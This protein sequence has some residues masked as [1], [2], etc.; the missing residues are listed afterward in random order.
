MDINSILNNVLGAGQQLNQQSSGR[1]TGSSLG[2]ALGSLLGGSASSGQ[3]GSGLGGML[4]G[5]LGNKGNLAKI[6]G[7]AAAAGIL[8]ML[9]GGSNGSRGLSNSI[10]KMGSLAAIGTLAY[11]AYQNWQQTSAGAAATA[12]AQIQPPAERSPAQQEE[13]SR[14]VLKSML[15]AAA[16]D[17]EISPAENQALLQEIGSQ[18]PEL[19]Q[20]LAN[21]VKNPPQPQDIAREI[22]NDPTLAMEVYLASR[23]VC[24]DLNRKE[25][26]YL[27]NL[28]SAL[29]LDDQLVQQLEKQAGF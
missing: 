11:K 28:Q 16:A 24:G 15:A 26:V 29:G 19:Q 5:L 6:G 23:I 21:L 18:D 3:S 20:W 17:G 7:G 25:I 13:N 9:L 14:V 1:L 12:P 10:M 4:G 22:G 2:D 27:G 8:S